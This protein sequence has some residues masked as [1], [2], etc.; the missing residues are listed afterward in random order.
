MQNKSEN[1]TGMFALQTIEAGT[2]TDAFLQ[3]TVIADPSAAVHSHSQTVRNHRVGTI[4]TGIAMVVYGVLFLLQTF[5]KS[6]SYEMIFD[7]WPCILIGLGIEMLASNFEAKKL[8]YDKG[9]IALL[10]VLTFFAMC[11]AGVQFGF[12]HMHW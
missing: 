1:R 12:D 11:M 6:I 9:A 10:F 7:L 8:T 2:G 3:E 5:T 4:T